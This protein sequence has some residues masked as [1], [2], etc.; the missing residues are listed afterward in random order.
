MTEESEICVSRYMYAKHLAKPEHLNGARRWLAHIQS[1]TN[2]Q[3]R[4]MPILY[5]ILADSENSGWDSHDLEEDEGSTYEPIN[6]LYQNE[7]SISI[8]NHETKALHDVIPWGARSLGEKALRWMSDMYP[9]AADYL[10]ERYP[11][12]N[13]DPLLVDLVAATACLLD[14]CEPISSKPTRRPHQN[15][16][17][18]SWRIDAWMQSQGLAA[19]CLITRVHVLAA[20]CLDFPYEDGHIKFD[21][22]DAIW[23]PYRK[24]EIEKSL[25]WQTLE[26][27]RNNR[28]MP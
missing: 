12:Y 5:S 2:H 25:S 28:M 1:T 8:M 23:L 21:H 7:S 16:E 10:K 18:F 19:G 3:S 14:P 13:K 27:V 22:V 11:N 15:G 9:E 24:G 20:A 6:G 26:S 4:T 17:D